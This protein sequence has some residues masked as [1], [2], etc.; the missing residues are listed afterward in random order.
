LKSLFYIA[1]YLTV[2]GFTGIYL[3]L[4][5]WYVWMALV[6]CG[7]IILVSWHAKTTAYLCP[8]CGYEFEISILTD[9]F[10]PHGVDR[11]GGWKYLKCPNCPTDQEWRYSPRKRAKK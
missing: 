3:L 8:R 6:A 1:I 9:F 4:S 2:I 5:Y 10:S 7:L 11:N